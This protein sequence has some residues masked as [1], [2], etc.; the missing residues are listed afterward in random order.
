MRVL[1]IV[2]IACFLIK[3]AVY[4]QN[5]PFHDKL[6]ELNKLNLNTPVKYLTEKDIEGSPYLHVNFRNGTVVK[7]NDARYTDIPLRFNM[8]DRSVEFIQDG[9]VLKVADPQNVVEVRI[10]SDLFIYSP[11][12]IARKK[13]HTF[14]QVVCEGKYRLLRMY[15]MKVD[16]L[17]KRKE[18][19]LEAKTPRF[20]SLPDK[21][22]MQYRNGTALPIS[23]KK[24]LIKILQPIPPKIEEYIRKNDFQ[25]T[26]EKQLDE[27]FEIINQVM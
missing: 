13:S 25:I 6:F 4:A 20:E 9:K 17:E 11:F 8:Y 12:S 2:V 15:N 7:R 1:L 21:Y 24:Q 16:G 18:P 27:L 23:T 3:H 5:A 19:Y 26:R 22:F 14:F 10:G